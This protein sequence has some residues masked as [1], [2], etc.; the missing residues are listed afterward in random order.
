MPTPN[1]YSA[2][3]ERMLAEWIAQDHF[4][5]WITDPI[6]AGEGTPIRV[7]EAT[8]D[9]V[10]RMGSALDYKNPLWRNDAYARTTDWGEILPLPLFERY[11]C[12]TPPF[13]HLTVPPDVASTASYY[14]GGVTWH[15]R[16]RVRLGDR[17]K[18]YLERPK[19][20]DLSVDADAVRRLELR[21]VQRFVNQRDED[22][23]SLERKVFVT[24]D[25]AST[26]PSI[27][28]E[29]GDPVA[30]AAPYS[31]TTQEI[32]HFDQIADSETIRG[33]EPRLWESVAEGDRLQPI[34]HGPITVWHDLTVFACIEDAVWLPVREIQRRAPGR[35][36][37]VVD[38]TTNVSHFAAEWHLDPR[39]A[40][41]VGHAAPG[42]TML[43]LERAY[44]RVLSNWIGD[45]GFVQKLDF[46]NHADVKLGDTVV[47]H[48]RVEGKDELDGERTVDITVW[49][50]NQ[51]G[52]VVGLGTA[53]VQLPSAL[54]TP[55][56]P[57]ANGGVGL[58]VGER[59]RINEGSQWSA[60]AHEALTGSLAE[61][62][63]I[64]FPGPFVDLRTVQTVSETAPEN[65]QI[66]LP[67]A[68]VTPVELDQ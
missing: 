57:E 22:V 63:G 16:R 4:V 35:P 10:A 53:H 33:S 14:W 18:C 65:G 52:V 21:T 37:I 60:P 24:I 40:Q 19:L 43:Q 64:R 15:M 8:H 41:A 17:L 29:Y 66:T 31:Y 2:A 45:L 13:I 61:I 54:P 49:L 39:V 59:V 68:S 11:V 55:Y 47:A 1:Q 56:E 46:R 9:A 5:G 3:E 12:S 50:E 44:A 42:V 23:S 30:Q 6:P 36:T 25:P 48:G 58:R 28:T 67:S 7:R 62:V 34:V 27:L 26:A 38:P 51:R 20:R 32:D